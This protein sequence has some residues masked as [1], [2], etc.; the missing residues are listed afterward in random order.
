MCTYKTDV[1]YRNCPEGC[2]AK[3][4]IQNE[5]LT[6]CS[7]YLSMMEAKFNSVDRNDTAEVD[8]PHQLSVFA[9]AG[10]PIGKANF[11]QVSYED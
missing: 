7:R 6:F 5:C 9:K 2:V 1:R 11:K 4:Y 10:K 3:V 8:P